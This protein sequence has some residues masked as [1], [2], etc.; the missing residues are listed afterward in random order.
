ME[1]GEDPKKIRVLDIRPPSRQDL[2]TG[3]AQQVT[4][5]QVDVSNAAAVFEAFKAPWP[6]TDGDQGITVFHT[7]ANIRFYE[8]DIRLLPRSSK[9]NYNGTVNVINAAKETGANTLIYTSSASVSVRRSRFWLWPWEKQPTYF[10]QVYKDDDS[11]LPKQHD[12]FFSNYAASK[13]SAEMAVRA[14]DKSPTTG[15]HTLR[16]GCVRPG[17]GI[18]GPGGDLMCG[19][20]LVRKH[21]PTW[22]PNIL[23]SFTYVENGALAHLCYEQRLIELERGSPNPDIGGQA[24][25]VTDAGPP[26]TYGDVY[27]ALSTLD[28]ETVFPIVSPTLMLGL[29]QVIEFFY[30][31]KSLLSASGPFTGRAIARLVPTISGDVVNLQP[32]IFALI[33][34]HLIFDDSRARLPPAKG[35]LGYY[36]PYTTLEGLCKTADEYFKSDKNGEERSLSGGVSFGF[37]WKK[38][39][40]MSR[41][42]KG[43]GERLGVN[44]VTV[45]N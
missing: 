20:Y 39:K 37:G 9:V 3:V 6:D 17:N 13:L 29:S 33:M 24:F 30:V 22:V 45:L 34:I 32:P 15:S 1:R 14:A 38:S 44:A 11:H 12:H 10:I 23:Q 4:F 5:L 36:G 25:T 40:G 28:K 18:F 31:S 2:R 16:T 7:A 21:N 41:A 35:G 27:T 19:A 26:L 42:R 43:H 8:R